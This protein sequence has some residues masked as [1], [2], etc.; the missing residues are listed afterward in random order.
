M[1]EEIIKEILIRQFEED[2]LYLHKY[3]APDDIYVFAQ[4]LL[5]SSH[6]FLQVL[7]EVANLDD[8]ANESKESHSY[9][10]NILGIL[11]AQ[12]SRTPVHLN[13]ELRVYQE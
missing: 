9:I 13:L 5:M 8:I 7:S 4:Q 1:S 12:A 3:I 6:H 2:V 11:Q 10:S